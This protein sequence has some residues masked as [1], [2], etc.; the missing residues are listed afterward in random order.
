MHKRAFFFA[1]PLQITQ[2][3]DYAERLANKPLLVVHSES[4]RICPL[5]EEVPLWEKLK[6]MYGN[7]LRVEL[8]RHMEH[9]DM[10]APPLKAPPLPPAPF[11]L[12]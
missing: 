11:A 9:G 7:C 6:G 2:S 10:K 12:Q 5:A 4:D 8:V 1:S 3:K